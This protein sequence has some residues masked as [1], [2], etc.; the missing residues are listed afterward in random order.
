M[1][2][3]QGEDIE[4]SDTVRQ[5]LLVTDDT[6]HKHRRLYRRH[7]AAVMVLIA[8]TVVGTCILCYAEHTWGLRHSY[9]TAVRT[10]LGFGRLLGLGGLTLALLGLFSVF[11]KPCSLNCVATKLVLGATPLLWIIA[12]QGVLLYVGSWN[13]LR[14]FQPWA[15]TDAGV[16]AIQQWLASEGRQLANEVGTDQKDIPRDDKYPK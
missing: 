6:Y 10:E 5:L 9:R 7:A 14:G 11:L 16:E 2:D 4:R 8:V 15:R 3:D 12:A 13:Y 1:I